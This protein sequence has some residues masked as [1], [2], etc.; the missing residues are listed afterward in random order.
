MNQETKSAADV[1]AGRCSVDRLVRRLAFLGQCICALGPFRGVAYWKLMLACEREPNRVIEWAERC[2][3]E[4]EMCKLRGD[5]GGHWALDSW[6]K[7][8]RHQHANYISANVRDH[9]WL[10]VARPM[11][12]EERTQAWGVTRVAIRWIA[13]LGCFFEL[14]NWCQ[15]APSLQ[16][17]PVDFFPAPDFSPNP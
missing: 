9:R 14:L 6:A 1:T 4:A 8:L 13:L 15:T 12:G 7:S 3:R 11:P 5:I 2:E 17:S 16:K 10:P